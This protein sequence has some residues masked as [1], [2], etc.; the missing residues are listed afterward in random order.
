VLSFLGLGALLMAV[1]FAYQKDWL[2]LRDT[3]PSTESEG[4]KVSNGGAD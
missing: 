1:S 4:R 2:S 3:P